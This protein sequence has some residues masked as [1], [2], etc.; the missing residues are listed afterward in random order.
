VGMFKP[1]ARQWI[2]L[3]VDR[4]TGGQLSKTLQQRGGGLS[5]AA[6]RRGDSD[7]LHVLELQ[8]QS[9]LSS[10]SEWNLSAK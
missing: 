7:S 8:S 10:I 5:A 1:A 2:Y 9:S 3:G 6:A 4:V